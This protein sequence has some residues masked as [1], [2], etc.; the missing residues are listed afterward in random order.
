MISQ[1][2][3][4]RIVSG[5]GAG[6]AVA[7]RKL[8][9]RIITQSLAIPPGIIIEFGDADAVSSYFG[10]GSEEARRATAYFQFISKSIVSPSAISF[11]RWVATPIAPMVVGDSFQ[12]TLSQFAGFTAGLLQ[13][14]V[15]NLPVQITGIDLSAATDLTNVASI[16]QTSIRT[17]TDPQLVTATVTYNSN[18]NQFVLSGAVPGSGSISVTPS[19]VVGDLSVALGWAS[20]NTVLVAGQAADLPETAI[21]KSAAVSNNFGSFVFTSNIASPLTNDQI[22]AVSRWNAAQNNSYLYSI[23]TLASNAGTLFGLIK[24]NSGSAIS[25]LSNVAA[26]DFIEQSPCEILAATNYNDVGATQNYMFYQFAG[27]NIT[28]SDDTT[29]DTLDKVRANY[30]GVTQEAGQQLAFYQRGVLCGG[31]NDAVD[32]NVYGNEMWLKSAITSNILTLLIASPDL[33]ASPDGAAS[34]L[35][36]MQPT[37]TLAG[38]NGTFTSGKTFTPVQQQFITRTTNDKNAWRQVQTLGYWITVTFS[39]YVNANNGLTEWKATYKLI[40][41]KGDSIRFVDGQ[42]IM[43]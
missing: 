2:R 27:R 16:I 41:S 38:D 19:E 8:I 34:V 22:A 14:N 1:G 18:T 40:Y 10:A 9:L 11:V 17:S 24:G 30:I 25:I 33:P 31:S 23:P 20:A 42:D 39:S 43:I 28:V 29:A 35:G 6:A 37:L 26:N 3:Y 5:V 32:M 4:I 7:Q 12:K 15:G 36:A 13:I 21:A